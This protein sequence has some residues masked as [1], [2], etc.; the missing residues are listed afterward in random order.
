MCPG[1]FIH[2]RGQRG[3]TGRLAETRDSARSMGSRIVQTHI[4]ASRSA[5]HCLS[6]DCVPHPDARGLSNRFKRPI[7]L[8]FPSPLDFLR[9]FALAFGA[10]AAFGLAAIALLFSAM[11]SLRQSF[12]L[13]C[14]L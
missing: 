11:K 12:N 1:I 10:G 7:M 14:K 13:R 4:T 6:L 3:T 2:P 9:A 5:E 8:P